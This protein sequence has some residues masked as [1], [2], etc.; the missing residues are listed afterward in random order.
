MSRAFAALI[1]LA[2]LSA[3]LDGRTVPPGPPG[4]GPR[5]DAQSSDT[6][7][8]EADA[9]EP[10]DAGFDDAGEPIDLGFIDSGEE[11]FDSGPPPDSGDE[12][13]DAGFIDAGFPDVGF[14][15]SGVSPADAG[16]VSSGCGRSHSSGQFNGNIMVDGR[17]RT[18]L[19]SVPNNY[20]PN[21]NYPLIFGF[22]GQSWLGFSFRNAPPQQRMEADAAGNAIFVYPD[23]LDVG[24]G[25]G[26]DL[27]ANGYDVR[28]FEVLSAALMSDYCV[29]P[30]RVFAFGTSY[31]AYFTNTLACSRPTRL[32]GAAA[33]AGGGPSFSCS[34]AVSWWGYHAMDDNTVGF[35]S[36][37]RS[38]DNWVR[39]NQCST[40]TTPSSPSPC[41]AYTGCSTGK[42][43]E[44]C[45]VST[46]GHVP[47]EWTG[48]AMWTFFRSL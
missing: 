35:G 28:Y 16:V 4:G 43:V 24:G 9:G 7:S 14:P 42:R 38:R 19:L 48:T 11:P 47:A 12:P 15:D 27:S 46:G 10:I 22:H 39:V 6:G 29:D 26:W 45:G 40:N 41:V 33:S 44:W 30:S 5:R 8:V 25:T 18:Y 17:N 13:I 20:N 3:C 37:T 1:A 31:G 2:T 34:G 32:R 36:G 21:N 23:G